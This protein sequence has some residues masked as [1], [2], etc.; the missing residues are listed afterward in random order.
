MPPARKSSPRG[1]RRPARRPPPWRMGLPYLQQHHYDLLGL[2]LVCLG[3]FLAFPLYLDWDGGR[4]GDWTV[5]GA[6]YVVGEGA[7]VVPLGLVAAGAVLVLRPVLPAARP[8]R[9]GAACL[10]GAVTLAFPPGTFGL[11]PGAA[12]EHWRAE[13][14]EDRGGIVG[15]ALHYGTS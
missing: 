3:V 1:R 9:S 14:F 8:F 5:H 7:Y 12:S 11:G 10:L 15:D 4:M 6:L 2:S 13:L